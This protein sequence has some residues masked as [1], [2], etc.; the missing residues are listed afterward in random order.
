M[1]NLSANLRLTRENAALVQELG[2]AYAEIEQLENPPPDSD[3]HPDLSRERPSS[4]DIIK[5]N[6]MDETGL[7]ESLNLPPGSTLATVAGTGSMDGM[8]DY[9]H[10]GILVPIGT[11]APYR[12]EDLKV[13]DVAVYCPSGTK[14]VVHRIWE[15][16]EDEDGRK[17]TFW[18]DNNPG[19]DKWVLRDNHLRYLLVGVIY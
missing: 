16:Q 5:R 13:G 8:M 11:E 1:C 17:Y 14:L 19:P 6:E 4:R 2:K 7:L 9:G 3:W 10:N 12:L 15:I 18:G